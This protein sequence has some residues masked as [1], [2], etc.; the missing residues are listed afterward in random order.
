MVSASIFPAPRLSGDKAHTCIQSRLWISNTKVS[1]FVLKNIFSGNW[2]VNGFD[3]FALASSLPLKAWQQRAPLKIRPNLQFKGRNFIK[4]DVKGWREGRGGE[5]NPGAT[6]PVEMYTVQYI[7]LQWPLCTT[8]GWSHKFAAAAVLLPTLDSPR[9]TLRER[10]PP[11][12]H[13]QPTLQTKSITQPLQSPHPPSRQGRTPPEATAGA[14]HWA[15]N[16][17][18]GSLLKPTVVLTPEVF[19]GPANLWSLSISSRPILNTTR[20]QGSATYR[21]CR[22]RAE[23]RATCPNLGGNLQCRGKRHPAVLTSQAVP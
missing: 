4:L 7:G 2:A 15:A 1:D 23:Q 19:R 3:V 13:T 8:T 11:Q 5:T 21:F 12:P 9:V 20:R 17:A 6:L 18:G 10:L 16:A 22:W 14:S